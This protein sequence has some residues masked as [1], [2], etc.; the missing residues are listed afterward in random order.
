MSSAS[1]HPPET[2]T[3]ASGE[4]VTLH[5]SAHESALWSILA[6]LGTPGGCLENKCE[7]CKAEAYEAVRIAE[8]ALG[9]SAEQR[10]SRV[11]KRK[12]G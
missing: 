9:L 4:G 1:L 7:G 11:V 10:Q 6:V 3:S 12:R 8:E 2:W 5:Y